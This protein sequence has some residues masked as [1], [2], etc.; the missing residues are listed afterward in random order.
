VIDRIKSGVGEEP[1]YHQNFHSLFKDG[2]KPGSG[3][4]GDKG[5]EMSTIFQ[6]P[7]TT[8]SDHDCSSF[9]IV[10]A[11]QVIIIDRVF[12]IVCFPTMVTLFLACKR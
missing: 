12:K 4:Q 10:K 2:C 11:T 3:Y 6:E 9:D 8:T 5:S 1:M 7:V